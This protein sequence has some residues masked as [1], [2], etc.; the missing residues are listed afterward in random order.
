MTSGSST[1][2][3]LYELA[4]T[5]E[6]RLTVG[7]PQA[8]AADVALGKVVQVKLLEQ[9]IQPFKGEISRVSGGLDVAT[10][11]LDVEV[12]IRDHNGPLLPGAYVEVS[13]PLSGSP[14]ALLLPPNALQFRQDGPRVAVVGADHRIAIKPVKLGR[15]LGKQVE[16]L[17][18]L[19]P[20]DQIVLNP[21]DA[22][23]AGEQVQ[24]K[25]APANKP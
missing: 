17:A 5:D 6:L 20:Q 19:S 15:D 3:P 1:A 10:R 8:Y 12:R 16:V 14:K 2:K 18:G 13:L 9:P 24:T 22:I 4:Q 11:T 23:E 25:A 7:V 21:P